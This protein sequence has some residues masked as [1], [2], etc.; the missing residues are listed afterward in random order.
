VPI[1]LS[2][3]TIDIVNKILGPGGVKLAYLPQTFIYTDNT[4]TTGSAP[5]P[6]KTAKSVDSG[7]LQVSITRQLTQPVTTTFTLGRV[8]VSATDTAGSSPGSLGSPDTTAGSDA[9]LAAASSPPGSTPSLA[10]TT[11]PGT[12]GQPPSLASPATIGPNGS[13][14]LPSLAGAARTGPSAESVYLILVVAAAAALGGSQLIRLVAIR[15][16]LS[17]R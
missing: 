1:P 8:Y 5:D 12:P 16:A 4:T 17:R 14:A 9:G 2:A 11:T 13:R 10:G 6:S 3:A 7:A 15:L